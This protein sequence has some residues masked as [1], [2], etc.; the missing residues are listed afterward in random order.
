MT[1]PKK[2]EGKLPALPSAEIY[3]N[4][5][6]LEKGEYTLKIIQKNKLITKTIFKKD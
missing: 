6:H 1:K 4:V 5:D 2:Y 3:L